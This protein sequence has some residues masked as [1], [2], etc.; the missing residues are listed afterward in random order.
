MTKAGTSN[1][2]RLSHLFPKQKEV[3]PMTKY[4]SRKPPVPGSITDPDIIDLLRCPKE[5]T[6]HARKDMI[7][8]NAS[9]RNDMVLQSVKDYYTEPQTFKVFIRRSVFLP[10][11]F[12]IGLIWLPK[13]SSRIILLRYNGRHGLNRSVPHQRVP[14]IHRL[15]AQDIQMEKYDPHQAAETDRYYTLE[16]AL[17]L[18]LKECNIIDGDK[19]FPQLYEFSLFDTKGEDKP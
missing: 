9:E 6:S 5:I 8:E 11:D 14:H 13:G 2:I 17:S 4:T 7:I 18:F 19:D 12:S 10:E 3:L 15:S 16:D 1:I